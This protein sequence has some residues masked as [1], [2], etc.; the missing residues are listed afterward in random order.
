MMELNAA[1]IKSMLF[2]KQDNGGCDGVAPCPTPM[3]KFPASTPIAMMYVP[4]QEWETP[5]DPDLALSRGTIFPS[6]DLPF[7][8]K[9]AVRHGNV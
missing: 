8:G 1:E 3:T 6:L 2:G 7:I 5:Y 4:Y 9:E